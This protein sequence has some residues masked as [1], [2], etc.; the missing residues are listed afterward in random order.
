MIMFYV[1]FL[2]LMLSVAQLV[3]FTSDF[4]FRVVSSFWFLTGFLVLGWFEGSFF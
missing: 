4:D 2:Y 1:D 3:S